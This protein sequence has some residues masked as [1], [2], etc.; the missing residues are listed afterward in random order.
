MV[1]TSKSSA[2]EGVVTSTAR[3]NLGEIKLLAGIITISGVETTSTSTSD[4]KTGVNKSK[5]TY[6]TLSIAGQKF[7]IGPDG[8][9]AT[10]KTTPIPGL[11]DNPDR[12][13]TRL[14]SSH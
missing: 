4:G 3:S 1:P 12:Q 2:A 11:N 14:N 5:A 13:S 7:A 8:V 9:E 6:G 10:G